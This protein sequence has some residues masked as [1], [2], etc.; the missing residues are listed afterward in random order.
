M[1]NERNEPVGILGGIGPMATVYFMQRVLDLTDASRDQDH[2][3][4]LV[5]NHASIPDRTAYLLGDSDDSPGPVMAEDAR[6]LERAG[7]KFIAVPCNTAVA[8]QDEISSAVGIPVID[9]VEVTVAAA[10]DAVPGITSVGILATDGTLR[11]QT[12]HRAAEAAG[13]TPVVPD[14]V[15]QK[16]VMSMIYDGVKAGMPVERDRFDAVVAHLRAKGAGAVMLACTELSILRTD[17]RVD[18][19]GVVDSLDA[20]AARTVTMAGG[21]LR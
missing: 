10:Q 21:R 5:W 11:A 17:L 8:F 2:L 18:D 15:V 6:Q 20:L 1:R 19:P 3:D 7:A 12:Y 9:I 4:M 14:D 16:D 13:L